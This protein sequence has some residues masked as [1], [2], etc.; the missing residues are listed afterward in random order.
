MKNKL[1][2]LLAA[3]VLSVSLAGCSS[4]GSSDYV[5]YNTAGNNAPAEAYGIADYE[6]KETAD[7]EAYMPAPAAEDSGAAPVLSQEKMVYRGSLSIETLEYAETVKNIKERI[8]SYS[9]IVEAEEQ[10]DN[11]RTWYNSGATTR[12]TCSLNMTVRIPTESFEAFLDDM[13]GSGK[14]TSRTTNVENISRR[15]NDNDTAIAALEKQEARLLEMMDQADT[16]EDMIMIEQRL[17]EVQTE[18]NQKR[19]YKSSMDT[20][21]SYSTV[22]LNVREVLEYTP[23]P[24]GQRTGTFLNRLQNAFRS[25]WNSFLWLLESLLFL[26]IHILPWL[27]IIIPCAWLLRR[28]IRKNDARKTDKPIRERSFPRRRTV[29]EREVL[30]AE[31]PEPKDQDKPVL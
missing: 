30:K 31:E 21:V 16:I 1:R 7:E 5:S 8:R 14:V 27:V 26:I 10:Y 23:T 11:D 12:G 13:S 15:Y 24:E 6:Y 2:F 20:D 4:G 18:L 17:T 22:Y 3:A 19:S 29:K 9:G 25:S 28:F